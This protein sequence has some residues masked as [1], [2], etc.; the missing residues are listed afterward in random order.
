VKPSLV[1][2]DGHQSQV[3]FDLPQKFVGLVPR[4]GLKIAGS[5]MAAS[6]KEGICSTSTIGK[7]ITNPFL[8]FTYLSLPGLSQT[9]VIPP[10]VLTL[11]LVEI[12]RVPAWL[13]ALPCVG[14]HARYFLGM[15]G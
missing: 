2:L 7:V 11:G 12:E 4:I 6:W 3:V 10:A 8:V 5:R 14:Q 13:V 15:D 1:L 9:A